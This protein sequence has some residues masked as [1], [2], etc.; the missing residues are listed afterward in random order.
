MRI[1]RNHNV[2]QQEAIRKINT[3]VGDLM[4]RQFPGGIAI[5]NQ[6]KNWSGDTMN[7]SFKAKKDWVPGIIIS[8]TVRV[9]DQSVVMD[10]DLPGLITTFFSED[11]IRDVIGKQFDSLLST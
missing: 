5:K 6:S 2:G 8:G 3:F 1:E 10:A 11:K 7:F 9:T 4:Q